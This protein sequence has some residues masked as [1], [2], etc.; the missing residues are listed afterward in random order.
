MMH[1]QQ[2]N[3]TIV[4]EGNNKFILV[5]LMLAKYSNHTS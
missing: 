2:N 5:V 4:S 3:H 1:N